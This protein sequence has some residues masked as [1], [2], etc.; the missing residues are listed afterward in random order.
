DDLFALLEAE[1]EPPPGVLHCF[2]GGP[3]D[4]VRA[5]SLGFHVSFAGNVTYPRAI[6]SQEA[7]SAVDESRLLLETD[8]PFLPP[9][10]FRGRRNEP[11]FLEHTLRFLAELRRADPAELETATTRNAERLFGI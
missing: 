3:E 6:V 5:S 10:P 7:A 8:S 9:H 1:A 2:A 11:A 4:A